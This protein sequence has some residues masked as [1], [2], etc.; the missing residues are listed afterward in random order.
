[1]TSYAK[2]ASR[3]GAP[4]CKASG[5]GETK[6]M[7]SR[8]QVLGGM[9]VGGLAGCSSDNASVVNLFQ[10]TITSKQ[11]PANAY[12]LNAQQIHDLPYATLGIRI[13]SAPAAVLVLG[14]VD[15][16]ALRWVSA[17]RVVFITSGGWLTQTKGLPRDLAATRW[18]G[19]QAQDPLRSFIETGNL[20]PRGVYREIDLLRANEKAV[21]IESRFEQRPDEVIDIQ[22]KQHACRRL[23][24]IAKMPSWRWGTRNSFWLDIQ[25]GR[26]WRSIQ[27]F[28]PEIPPM[29]LEVLKP[30][31]TASG[32]G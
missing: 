20:P 30:L 28:C 23:D 31:A 14:T 4:H 13:G 3:P 6:G 17:D 19:L 12:P 11:P 2:Q 15:G 16:T 22:G 8:R 27:Q 18:T 1:M 10:K 26:V 29:R 7:F 25:D 21:A 5:T 9:M 32:T 24:E